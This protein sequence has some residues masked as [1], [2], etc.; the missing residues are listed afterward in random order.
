MQYRLILWFSSRTFFESKHII[1]EKPGCASPCGTLIILVCRIKLVIVIRILQ[2]AK[3]N[4][5][6]YFNPL[7]SNVRGTNHALSCSKC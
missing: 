7:V 2:E 4:Q 3:G 1:L 6:C 5:R